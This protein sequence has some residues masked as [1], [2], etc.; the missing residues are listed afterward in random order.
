MGIVMLCSRRGCGETQPCPTHKQTAHQKGYD[1]RWRAYRL[2]FIVQVNCTECGRNHALCEGKCREQGKIVPTYAVDH[3]RPHRGDEKLFW[4]HSNHQG[5]CQAE[6]N[7][8][9][10]KER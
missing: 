5:L 2:W 4:L 8:K 10:A 3:I 1:A 9:S 6:H 7:A